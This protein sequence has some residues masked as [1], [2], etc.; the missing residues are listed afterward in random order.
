MGPSIHREQRLISV[1]EAEALAILACS[2]ASCQ[3][4][5][6]KT[7][8]VVFGNL[9]EMIAELKE[10]EI[11]EV[12]VDALFREKRIEHGIFILKAFVT[13]GALLKNGL[14]GHFERVIFK[15]VRPL[16]EEEIEPIIQETLEA[17]KELKKDLVEQSFTVRN[18]YFGEAVS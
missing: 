5:E 1:S 17:E 7:L 12:R 2:Y 15:N 6:L 4:K 13:A 16:R 10:K 3:C 8:K 9:D 11:T 14:V 18:G